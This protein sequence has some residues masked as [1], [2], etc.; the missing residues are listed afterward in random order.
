MYR[1]Y[2]KICQNDEVQKDV[3][4]ASKFDFGMEPKITTHLPTC[5]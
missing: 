2:I 1:N 3:K 4:N 5:F